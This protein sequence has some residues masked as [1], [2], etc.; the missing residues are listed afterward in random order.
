M[1]APRLKIRHATEYD[2]ALIAG[3]GA[4]TFEE[5]FG[6]D[7]KPEDM[8]NYLAKNFALDKIKSELADPGSTFL[9]AYEN[10]EPI[11]YAK[12][13]ASEA[14]DSVSGPEPVE[15]VRIYVDQKLIGKGYGSVLMKSC[16]EQA[17]HDGYKTMWLGVW[18]KNEH[19]IRFYEKW[20]FTIVGPRVFVLGSDVQN[21]FIMQ[22]AIDI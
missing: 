6:P 13:E 16:I 3:I 11:G 1:P 5:T 18:E 9:L 8:Q 17:K 20:G 22:R 4:R 7:N 19:A 15:L 10:E 14:P 12:L 21:D 2:A